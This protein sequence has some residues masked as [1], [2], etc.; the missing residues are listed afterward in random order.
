MTTPSV[1]PN[2]MESEV[3]QARGLRSILSDLPL[4]MVRVRVRGLGSF[5]IL[6]RG[7]TT[8]SV[9]P[10]LLECE[11]P[12]APQRLQ[13]APS[14]F[15]MRMVRLLVRGLLVLCVFTGAL[16]FASATLPS[17]FG[18]KSMVVSSGSMEPAIRTGDAVLIRPVVDTSII[19]LAD[20]IT[21]S[22]YSAQGMVT[23]RVIEITQIDGGTYFR[24]QGDANDTPDANLA[25]ADSVFGKVSLTLPRVG[26][27]L[28]FASTLWGKLLLIGVP[29][30]ILMAQEVGGLLRSKA[31]SEGI[32]GRQS[33]LKATAHEG[34]MAA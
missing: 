20:V 21:F 19:G 5:F 26:Y 12:L 25:P 27:L 6:K 31:P 32:R 29:L 14:G 24:T 10:D 4:R 22:P 30:I 2:L 15:P 1:T 23:H 11:P 8:R 28:Y 18:L 34:P 33:P 16:V 9:K 13:T 17:L 7:T 3:P